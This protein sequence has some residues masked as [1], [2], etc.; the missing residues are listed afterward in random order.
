MAAGATPRAVAAHQAAKVS[1]PRVGAEG[2]RSPANEDSRAA[3]P[4]QAVL[5]VTVVA[6]PI[7]AATVADITGAVVIT[8][9]AEPIW[10]S[11]TADTPDITVATTAGTTAPVTMTNGAIGFRA[12]QTF[13]IMAATVTN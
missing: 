11:V 1:Q 6:A 9:V 3:R 4:S 12:A 8:A 13:R 10:D 2:N 7:I 5:A